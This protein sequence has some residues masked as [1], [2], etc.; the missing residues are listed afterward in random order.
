MKRSELKRNAGITRS[1]MRSKPTR[2]PSELSE[3]RGVVLE[4]SGGRCEARTEVCAH[5]ARHVH[6]R[7]LRR[8]GDHSPANLLHVCL[9]CHNWIHA[10]PARSYEAGWLLKGNE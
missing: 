4:R 2:E 8:F 3:S 1:A 10:N 6:H 7:Q 9:S 5:I